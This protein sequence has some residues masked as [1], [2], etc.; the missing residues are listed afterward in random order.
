M[1][2]IS[3]VMLTIILMIVLLVA[4]SDYR[5]LFYIRANEDM[6]SWT[7]VNDTPG[8][9][10]EYPPQGITKVDSNIIICNHHFDKEKNSHKTVIVDLDSS[11]EDGTI[12]KN[13]LYSY[14]NESFSQ[15]LCYWNGYIFEVENKVTKSVVNIYDFEALVSGA[16]SE[17]VFVNQY[18]L[19]DKGG[20]DIYVDDKGIIISDAVTFKIYDGNLSQLTKKLIHD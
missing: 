4:F 3:I 1:K 8:A 15:G 13:I 5:C 20:Q 18:Y 6:T 19:P 11:F 16:E 9:Q 2:K 7:V 10:K 14:D 17:E 12:E